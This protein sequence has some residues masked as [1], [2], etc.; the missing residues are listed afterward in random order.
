MQTQV[1]HVEVDI[2][3]PEELVDWGIIEKDER[4]GRWSLLVNPVEKEKEKRE[5]QE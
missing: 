5:D 3:A 2:D 1:F 4:G